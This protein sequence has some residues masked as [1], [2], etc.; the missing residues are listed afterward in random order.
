MDWQLA[1]TEALLTGLRAGAPPSLRWY[2][3]D[4]PALVLGR[5]QK[6]ALLDHPA[7]RAA[8]MRAYAR[9]SGGGTV[10]INHDALSLD[11]ALPSGHPLL[12]RDV[13]LSYRWVGEVWAAALG[14]LGVDGARALPAEE[15]RALPPLAPGDPVRLACYGMLS[16]WE[17]VVGARKVVGLSQVRRRAGALLPMGVHLR[18]E[19]R[20]L[21]ALLALSARARRRLAGDLRA[22]AAGLDELVGRKVTAAEVIAAFE[23]TMRA[24]LGVRLAPG[25]W[26]AEEEAAACHLLAE[27]FRAL[28]G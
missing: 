19:P 6:A 18:W 28:D 17:V 4:T 15:A 25:A 1:H 27:E 24:R 12:N 16:P 9:T 13:T 14:A 8:R 26:L 11:I 5:S 2:L 10:L 3:P 20:P 21:A 22:R 7:L 23:A